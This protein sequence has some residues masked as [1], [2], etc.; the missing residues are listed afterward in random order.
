MYGSRCKRK[1]KL[2]K[3]I[4]SKNTL[5]FR[6]LFSAIGEY[7][8]VKIRFDVSFYKLWIIRVELNLIA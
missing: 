4:D 5:S 7:N 2:I 3:E 1:I 8:Y 6:W